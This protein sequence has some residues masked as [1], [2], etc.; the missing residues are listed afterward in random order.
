M[1]AIREAP[2]NLFRSSFHATLSCILQAS[3]LEARRHRLLSGTVSPTMKLVSR[4]L[5]IP[6]CAS[7]LLLHTAIF[8]ALLYLAVV[9]TLPHYFNQ[10]TVREL[11][12]R[13]L[14]DRVP[15]SQVHLGDARVDLLPFPH[16][17]LENLSVLL[18]GRMLVQIQR[19]DGYPDLG[20][21]LTGS[22]EPGSF[23]IQSPRVIVGMPRK[24]VEW[25]RPEDP[26]GLSTLL[27]ILPRV[28]GSIRNGELQVF[29]DTILH[30]RDIRADVDIA[31]RVGLT[32]Q[33]ETNFSRELSLALQ[34]D[35]GRSKLRGSL[36]TRDL[37]LELLAPFLPSGA[38]QWIGASRLGMD[39]EF[40]FSGGARFEASMRLKPS[41][42]Y[43]T[44]PGGK[45]QV[46]VR[47][48]KATI[49][50]TRNG[51]GIRLEEL[52][53]ATP[54]L[55]LG[56]SVDLGTAEQ[57]SQL[58][59]KAS[60]VH[61]TSLAATCKELFPEQD[62]TQSFSIVPEGRLP[63]IRITGSGKDREALL[64]NL[65]VMG[66]LEEGRIDLPQPDIELSRVGG[67]FHIVENALSLNDLTAEFGQSGIT[68]G[69]A[70]IGL[71]EDVDPL[72][73]HLECRLDLAETVRLLERIL[74]NP[75]IQRR[76]QGIETL[77][78]RADAS[79]SLEK[80]T[81]ELEWG[82]DMEHLDLRGKHADFPLPFSLSRGKLSFAQKTLHFVGLKGTVGKSS[83]GRLEGRLLFDDRMRISLNGGEAELALDQ[84][85]GTFR[86]LPATVSRRETLGTIDGKM[87]VERFNLAGPLLNP[88]QWDFDASGSLTRLSVAPP[89]LSRPLKISADSLSGN[90]KGLSWSGLRLSFSDSRIQSQGRLVFAEDSVESVRGSFQ[91]EVRSAEILDRLYDAAPVP[92]PLQLRSPLSLSD[93]RFQ[94]RGPRDFSL[95]AD[96]RLAGGMSGH[97]DVS[98]NGSEY[99]LHG[100]RLRLNDRMCTIEAGFKGNRLDVAYSGELAMRKLRTAFRHPGALQGELDGDFSLSLEFSPFRFLESRGTIRVSSLDLPERFGIPLLKLDRAHLEGKGKEVTVEVLRLR[101]NNRPIDIS[102]RLAIAEAANIL[103]LNLR[104]GELDRKWLETVQSM[105]ADQHTSDNT[106]NL[107]RIRGTVDF[108]I[109]AVRLGGLDI[110]P[111]HGAVDLTGDR[112][113]VLV[114][115]V[116]LCHLDPLGQVVFDGKRISAEL[117]AH[118]RE[119]DLAR[120]VSCFKGGEELISGEYALSLRSRTQG[121]NPS[122]LKSN[123][124]GNLRFLAKDGRIFGINILAKILALLNSSEIIFGRVPDIQEEGLGYNS[125]EAAGK[126]KGPVLHLEQA[127]VDGK[128]LK[129]A[130]NGDIDLSKRRMNLIVLVSPLKTVDRI[131]SWIPV[132]NY[133]LDNTLVTIPLRVS[134]KIGDP[135]VIPLSPQAVGSEVFGIMQRTLSLPFKVFQPLMPE[136]G[137]KKDQ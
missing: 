25:A 94:W 81:A 34:S 60:D 108:A 95:R 50:G 66:R 124:R 87:K 52:D 38:A 122:Q 83:I 22:P 127:I 68:A 21:L 82:I 135:L 103:E 51:T 19:L 24:A 77:Q 54:R 114:N 20:S 31:E 106:A 89:S 8:L 128:S 42:I 101:V 109:E 100:L 56:G 86:G 71:G 91:A 113:T 111:V 11:L 33:M 41:R 137:E 49:T 5:R 63:W 102:G 1:R 99:R 67:T 62:F 78:G 14:G 107:A 7:L 29:G 53:L 48:G 123:N 18:P 39:A 64:A 6:L 23:H 37:R 46:A 4:I 76:L 115:D 61:I 17:S 65:G 121:E 47:S 58:D 15:Q 75:D 30:M 134:G 126:F 70:E 116:G 10:A 129:I 36:N 35:P 93:A 130:A 45:S 28:K 104:A 79:F 40:S 85:A 112:I 125:I 26:K 133:I 2:L 136:E 105:A 90:R 59:L 9:L 80:T 44:S 118:V 96:F 132:V 3:R 69:R 110:S 16:I 97:A 72:S 131:I 32:L 12:A 57:G 88:R 13:E 74:D 84:L 117:S 120:T 119:Q 27:G 43:L 92:E 98:A 55:V 73:L